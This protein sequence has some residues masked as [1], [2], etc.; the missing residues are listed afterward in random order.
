MFSRMTRALMILGACAAAAPADDVLAYKVSFGYENPGEFL[1]SVVLALFF[2]A[3]DDITWREE[4]DV[5]TIAKGDEPRMIIDLH[6]GKVGFLSLFEKKFV[7]VEAVRAEKII[8][9]Y[10]FFLRRHLD[11]GDELAL[12][13][14]LRGKTYRIAAR[15]AGE[16]VI[17]VEGWP[18]PLP[19][20]RVTGL[21]TGWA[22]GQQTT[23][24]AFIGARGDVGGK[25]LKI[26][27][28]FTRWP[29]VTLTLKGNARE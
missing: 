22:K 15:V 23:I 8:T 26:S 7:P 9:I 12:D 10:D 24:E 4:G 25:I 21:I 27:F 16:G 2:V 13:Y 5:I 17:R 14:P 28:K 6:A 20:K 11:V 3:G 18:E 19:C 1:A 29:R